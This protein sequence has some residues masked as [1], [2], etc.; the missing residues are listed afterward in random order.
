[1][2][3]KIKNRTKTKE[4]LE[5]EKLAADEERARQEAGI[6]DEFQAKGFELV[7]WTQE[8]RG[9]IL[10]AIGLVL[11]VGIVLTVLT[12]SRASEDGAASAVYAEAME[13]W[14]G[15]VGP[16]LPGLSDA[17]KARFETAKEKAEKSREQFRKVI[18]EY[19]SSGAASLAHLYA[20]H[21][22]QDLADWDAAIEHYSAYID[23]HPKDDAL[24][25]AAVAG[26]AAAHESKGNVDAAIADHRR[27]LELS[28]SPAK[29]AAMFALARL[30]L[31]KGDK[32]QAKDYLDQ[33]EKQF[34]ES[35]MLQNAEPLRARLGDE[36]AKGAG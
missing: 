7:E 3:K 18:A 27:L 4:E 31:S 11:V 8:N 12:L 35:S 16:E 26:R 30:S 34:P 2:T 33:L 6:Q 32:A 17:N 21:A 14:Q 19:P 29:D 28:V 5:A 23:G 9:V 25:F 22:S 36:G 1:M 24:L 15:E 13:S 20:G 10:G